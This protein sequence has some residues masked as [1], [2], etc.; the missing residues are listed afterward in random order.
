M[1][2]HQPNILAL[3]W[4]FLL[5]MWGFM[6]FY[7]PKLG[8]ID[9]QESTHNRKLTGQEVSEL[10][11]HFKKQLSPAHCQLLLQGFFSSRHY[12]SSIIYFLNLTSSFSSCRLKVSLS[13][14]SNFYDSYYKCI[15][16]HIPRN[17]SDLDWIKYQFSICL[18][19]KQNLR[20]IM[21]WPKSRGTI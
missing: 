18:R 12:L 7:P 13:W 5:A 14:A 15:H 9:E 2:I 11:P 6:G 4:L 17:Y 8:L 20:E 21:S 1:F 10:G 16:F 19:R 3:S